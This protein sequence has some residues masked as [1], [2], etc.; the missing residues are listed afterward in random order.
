[1]TRTLTL[2]ELGLLVAFALIVGSQLGGL[3]M[4][5]RRG[6]TRNVTRV[7]N[8]SA[9]L[10]LAAVH[11]VLTLRWLQ[12]ADEVDPLVAL[13]SLPAANWGYLL[14]VVMII[15]VLAY[16]AASHVLALRAGLTKN[17][18]RLAA[19]GVAA[20]ILLALIG[21]SDA[22]WDLYLDEVEISFQQS[23]AAGLD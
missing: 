3:L 16:E 9:L 17:V 14:L 18:S 7:V 8:F 10:A 22:R 20:V 2:W 5:R 11:L 19:L 23:L 15:L 21:I 13:R 1:M 12:L 4:A 6:L